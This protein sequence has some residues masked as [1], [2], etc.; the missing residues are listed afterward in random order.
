MNKT[1]PTNSLPRKTVDLLFCKSTLA[2]ADLKK[3]NLQCGYII[4]L[5]DSVKLSAMQNLKIACLTLFLIMIYF[6]KLRVHLV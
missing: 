2:D 4:F 3:D 5:Q 6:L 1:T